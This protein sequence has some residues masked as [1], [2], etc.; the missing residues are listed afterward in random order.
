M[1]R[2]WCFNNINLTGT[3]RIYV[4]DAYSTYTTELAY[5]LTQTVTPMYYVCTRVL[6]Y[7]LDCNCVFTET[8]NS[9]SRIIADSTICNSWYSSTKAVV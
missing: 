2:H 5:N 6:M 3:C 8:A 4:Y 1:R 9:V 7:V